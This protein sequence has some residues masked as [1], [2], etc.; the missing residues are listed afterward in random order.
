MLFNREN[1]SS[2]IL[3]HS[4]CTLEALGSN[5]PCHGP[6]CLNQKNSE[7][8]SLCSGFNT[9][10]IN[11]DKHLCCVSSSVHSTPSL[12]PPPRHPVSLPEESPIINKRSIDQLLPQPQPNCNY[13]HH[14]LPGTK[15]LF[16]FH[17]YLFSLMK[18]PSCFSK[19]C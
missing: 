12:S 6:S 14:F 10:I 2:K 7:S 19:L 9:G 15:T 3:C 1:S 17:F 16:N 4:N 18:T 8:R 11:T 5:I 13:S